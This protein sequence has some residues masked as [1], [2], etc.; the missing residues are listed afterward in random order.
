MILLNRWV[1]IENKHE[2]IE[3]DESNILIMTDL[4]RE[5]LG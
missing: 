2:L 3:K 1:E 5:T 4:I